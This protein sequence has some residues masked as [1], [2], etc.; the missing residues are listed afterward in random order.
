MQN[1]FKHVPLTINEV[2]NSMIL[3]LFLSTESD[4][5]ERRCVG[6]GM[7]DMALHMCEEFLNVLEHG[8]ID[9]T[10]ETHPSVEEQQWAEFLQDY[11]MVVQ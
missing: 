3:I 2:S 8:D 1:E 6:P 5:A 9:V 7:I 4:N 10:A 11:Y